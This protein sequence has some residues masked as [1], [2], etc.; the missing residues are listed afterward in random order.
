[1]VPKK[2][3]GVASTMRR[4]EKQR[5]LG[6]RI[7]SQPNGEQ[8]QHYKKSMLFTKKGDQKLGRTLKRNGG[9]LVSISKDHTDSTGKKELCI[10][11]IADSDGR[12][13]S[14][15]TTNLKFQQLTVIV[16]TR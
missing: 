16:R 3:K 9:I 10:Q 4:V 7:L 15:V 1:M 5:K 2:L 8:S 11:Q 12:H 6:Y 13:G 14:G